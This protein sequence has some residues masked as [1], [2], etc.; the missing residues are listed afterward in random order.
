M[1]DEYAARGQSNWL[2]GLGPRHEG[3][4]STAYS[5]EVRKRIVPLDGLGADVIRNELQMIAK[6]LIE[7]S[8]PWP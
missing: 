1:M 6:E 5:E 2:D 8:F 3:S 4:H 7:G